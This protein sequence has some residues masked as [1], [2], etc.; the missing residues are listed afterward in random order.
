MR[1]DRVIIGSIL[2]SFGCKPTQVATSAIKPAYYEDLSVH[3]PILT[4]PE[5]TLNESLVQESQEEIQW[6]ASIKE[7]MDSVSRMIA[8]R[9]KELGYLEGFTIQVYTGTDRKE[10]DN[11]MKAINLGYPDLTPEI[12]YRQPSYKVKAGTYTNRLEAYAILQSLKE[13]FPR[14]LMIPERIRFVNE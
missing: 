11:A 10:A 3:R 8:R 7:E 2:L 13:Q 6:T 4:I 9:N 1:I 12:T 5:D 14:A